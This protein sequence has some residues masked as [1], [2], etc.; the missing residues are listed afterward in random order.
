MKKAVVERIIESLW[1]EISKIGEKYKTPDDIKGVPFSVVKL[2]K[3]SLTIATVKKSSLKIPEEA[4]A[5]AIQYLIENG[6][7]GK[8]EAC[9]IKASQSDPGPLNKATRKFTNNTMNI[10]YVLPILASTGVVGIDGKRKNKTW[11]KL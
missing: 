11:I 6:H 8:G 10:S 4:F 1:A 2:G 3:A 7:Y 5:A 9:L